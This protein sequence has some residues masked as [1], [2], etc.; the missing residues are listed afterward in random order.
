ML[1]H[2][3]NGVCFDEWN[4]SKLMWEKTISCC[5]LQP[6]CY[7]FAEMGPRTVMK[8]P[9]ASRFPE[10]PWTTQSFRP[11]PQVDGFILKANIFLYSL[12]SHPHTNGLL[13][14]LK[15]PSEAGLRQI[16]VKSAQNSGE[17]NQCQI[18]VAHHGFRLYRH[19]LAW[20]ACFNVWICFCG[21]RCTEMF[22]KWKL[23]SVLK[24]GKLFS[25]TPVYVQTRPSCQC[26]VFVK[27]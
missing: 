16:R 7:T 10:P 2:N 26:H 25:N 21:L 27:V 1:Q 20:H 17:R 13:G 15:T 5:K 9:Q 3:K 24:R 14:D 23:F 19:L 12:A 4:M 6:E 11:C 18:T 22:C 8:T